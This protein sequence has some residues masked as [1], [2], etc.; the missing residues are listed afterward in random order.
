MEDDVF[1]SRGTA[2]LKCSAVA[3]DIL[4]HILTNVAIFA[5]MPDV[6]KTSTICVTLGTRFG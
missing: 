3:H 4:N 2:L 5:F 1:G 6:L